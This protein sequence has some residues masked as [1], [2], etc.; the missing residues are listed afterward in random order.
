MGGHYALALASTRLG[1][2]R[3][4]TYRPS[5]DSARQEMVCSS[6]E[7]YSHPRIKVCDNEDFFGQGISRA[8]V[9]IGR[10]LAIAEPPLANRSYIMFNGGQRGDRSLPSLG[11]RLKKQR[12]QRGVSL[13]QISL[14]T[15][16]GTRFLQAI[17]HDQ[18]DQLPGG[19]FNKGFI[20]AYAKS[21]GADEDEA[22][23]DYLTAISPPSP[24]AEASVVLPAPPE[25][26]PGSGGF[27]W[28]TLALL[29]LVVALGFAV[30]GFYS[31]EETAKQSGPAPV[32]ATTPTNAPETSVPATIKQT[33]VAAQHVSTSALPRSPQQTPTNSAV[34]TNSAATTIPPTALFGLKIAARED[35][36]ISITADGK[37]ILQDTITAGT[38]KSI[39]ATKQIVVRTGNAGGLDFEFN[40]ERLP[41][42]GEPGEVKTLEFG[43][44]GLEVTISR[45]PVSQS[46]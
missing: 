22:I 24:V 6:R 21:V 25:P 30:W 28:G 45:K 34:L 26:R 20:R 13:D 11:A 15:K 41:A 46:P 1:R 35:A 9:T 16:I 44:D 19:I 27:P 37:Q 12:E 40:G 42:Q 10:T 43:P 7:A 14:T 38:Q 18:F 5:Q 23:A 32:P 3:P 36:W 2:A 4:K 33:P 17:E 8:L 29:L 39:R 31:R